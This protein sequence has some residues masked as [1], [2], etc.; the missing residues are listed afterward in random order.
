MASGTLFFPHAEGAQF[1]HAFAVPEGTFHVREALVA[2]MDRLLAGDVGGKV[3][4]QHV[5]PIQTGFPSEG[6]FVLLQHKCSIY[7]PYAQPR[8]EPQTFDGFR[9]AP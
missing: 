8:G 9:Y 7:C 3:G 2:G 5:A 1:Q 4:L 6:V